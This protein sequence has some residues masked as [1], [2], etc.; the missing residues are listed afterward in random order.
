MVG[1]RFHARPD[2]NFVYHHKILKVSYKCHDGEHQLSK[3][4]ESRMNLFIGKSKS[5]LS[6][7]MMKLVRHSQLVRDTETLR[8]ITHCLGTLGPVD[9]MVLALPCPDTEDWGTIG[10][11]VR[12]LEHLD[13]YLIDKE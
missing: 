1:Y 5:V 8:E 12:V 11:F 4:V 6:F 10:S 2:A 7:L 3:V 9:L 13:Q